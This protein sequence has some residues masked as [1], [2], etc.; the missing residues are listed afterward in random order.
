VDRGWS[1]GPVLAPVGG[2]SRLAA[3]SSFSRSCVVFYL[4]KGDQAIVIRVLLW[5][6]CSLFSS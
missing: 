6:F 5:G 4:F 3:G 1:E 2:C